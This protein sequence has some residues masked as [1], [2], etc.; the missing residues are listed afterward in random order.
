MGSYTTWSFVSV[1][2]HLAQS[3]LRFVHRTACVSFHSFSWV[4][5]CPSSFNECVGC[6]HLLTIV[7]SVPWI[8]VDRYLFEHIIS[9][10]ISL[11]SISFCG[12]F[13]LLNVTLFPHWCKQFSIHF[14][15]YR[16]FQWINPT[17]YSPIQ[18]SRIFPWFL[19][20]PI[21]N[22]AALQFPVH[23][24]LGTFFE[25]SSGAYI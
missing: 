5:D 19:V 23:N 18:C 4:D 7:N 22:S 3:F 1:F 9:F 24:L 10:L 16:T 21:I 2:F 13:S 11:N 25:G 14:H 20:F 6:F 17:I 8:C 15:C 12:M